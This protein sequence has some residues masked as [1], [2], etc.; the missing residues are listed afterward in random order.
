[1]ATALPVVGTLHR[2]LPLHAANTL[3]GTFPSPNHGPRR[4][5]ASPSLVVIHYTAMADCAAAQRVLCDPATEVSAHYLIAPNG[6]V[7]ALVPEDRRAWHAGRGSWGSLMDINSHSIGIELSNTGFAPFAAPLMDALCDLLPGILS[8]WS[9]PPHRVIGHSDMA[10]GRKIDP[11]PRF[12][13]ARL[14]KSGLAVTA[15]PGPLPAYD[16]SA[17]GAALRLIGYP[18]V[19]LDTVLPAF[20]LRHRPRYGGPADA[21]DLA[22]ATDLAHR[23]PVP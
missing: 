15:N 16:A 3:S 22:L 6:S 7:T 18:D 21:L 23:F 13:W 9:I 17:L 1:M 20:R 5:G 12:D 11:G 8:R 2:L 10:P 19:P 14:A 4:D